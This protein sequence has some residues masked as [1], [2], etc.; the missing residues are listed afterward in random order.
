[1]YSAKGFP[2]M[3]RRGF[4]HS[5]ICASTPAC[6]SA[7]LIAANHVL[8]RLLTPRHPPSALSSLTTS[9]SVPSLPGT[10]RGQG[11]GSLFE[12]RSHPP[13]A[14]PYWG[15]LGGEILLGLNESRTR[16]MLHVDTIFALRPAIQ[17]SVSA[18][19]DKGFE[20]STSGL[21]SPRS[22]N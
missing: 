17:L 2:G 5:D 18:V 9:S 8:H 7:Q 22:P 19:E 11:Q 10:L 13:K 20:P 15:P 12:I 1:M 3:T 14:A 21:Q 4:P 16:H 6:G